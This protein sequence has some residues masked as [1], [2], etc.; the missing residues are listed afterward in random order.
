MKE[1]FDK[2]RE[3]K[4]KWRYKSFDNI[5]GLMKFLNNTQFLMSGA[6][7]EMFHVIDLNEYGIYLIY[8]LPEKGIT[9]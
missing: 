9:Y 1:N 4:E 5:Q 8:L 3:N 7:E 2:V 6:G